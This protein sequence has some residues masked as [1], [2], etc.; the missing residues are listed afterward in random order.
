[1]HDL[2]LLRCKHCQA[3]TRLVVYEQSHAYIAS[4]TQTNQG[5]AI[6]GLAD[7]LAEHIRHHPAVATCEFDL[8]DDPGFETLTLTQ[9]YDEQDMLDRAGIISGL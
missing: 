1:M 2:V 5:T 8:G 9:L 7:W 4:T 6:L 3:T